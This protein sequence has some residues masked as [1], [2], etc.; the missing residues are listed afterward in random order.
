MLKYVLGSICF[1][2][3]RCKVFQILTGS[4]FLESTILTQ[5]N[6]LFFSLISYQTTPENGQHF[7]FIVSSSIHFYK[8]LHCV[9]HPYCIL[10]YTFKSHDWVPVKPISLLPT[11]NIL[12]FSVIFLTVVS[13]SFSLHFCLFVFFFFFLPNGYWETGSRYNKFSTL[14]L[15]I[16]FFRWGTWGPDGVIYPWSH[17]W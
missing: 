17:N 7:A 2:L 14:V 12:V 6:I 1:Y 4:V 16:L 8:H 3:Q 11:I 13:H 15:W 5:V 9:F 10:N